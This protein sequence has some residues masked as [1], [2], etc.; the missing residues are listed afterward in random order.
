V[1]YELEIADIQNNKAYIFTTDRE[2]AKA[3]WLENNKDTIKVSF[4]VKA[5]YRYEV[6]ALLALQLPEPK[7]LA[8][9]DDWMDRY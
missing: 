2:K 1:T 9:D 5:D 4:S 7:R 3:F 6:N 8:P